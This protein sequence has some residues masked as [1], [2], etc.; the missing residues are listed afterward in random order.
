VTPLAFALVLAAAPA[1]GPLDRTEPVPPVLREVGV[2]EHANAE[3]PLDLPFTDESGRKVT[4]GSYLAPKRP[5]I[6]TLNYYRCPMLCTLELNG[7]AEGLRGLDA[8]I[9]KEFDVVTVSID[10]KETPA[11]ATAKK[12]SYL[13]GYARP[14]AASGWHF[15]TGSASSIETLS[16]TLGFAA[17]YDPE[18][19]QYAHPAVIFMITPEGRVSRYLYGVRFDAKTLTLGLTEASEGRIG[20]A[21]DRFLLYCYHYDSRQ[22]RYALAAMKLM[23]AAGLATVLIFGAVLSS[24]WLRERRRTRVEA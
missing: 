15:L 20:S 4:L 2:T 5:V 6:L 9:G 19:D 22:G 13:E 23:R 14:G 10:P 3:L 1:A 16:K 12:Q 21:W 8:S 24:L 7:L 18:T 17:T 11:L